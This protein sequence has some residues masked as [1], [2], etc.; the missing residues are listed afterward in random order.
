MKRILLMIAV[1]LM[2]ISADAQVQFGVRG[3]LNVSKE[4]DQIITTIVGNGV[5]TEEI[6]FSNDMKWRAGVNVG[7]FVNI[8]ENDKFDLEIGLSYSMQ[9]YDDK[10]IEI[11]GRG[12]KTLDHKVTSHYLTIPIAEK[13][14]PTGKG[15]Y[16]EL[17]PQL[18][19]LLSK[20]A[21]VGGGD[22]YTPFKDDNRTLDFGILGGVGYVFPSGMFLNARY[23]HGLTETCKV[24]SGGKNRNLQLSLGY[25]F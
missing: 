2:A 22:S 12:E 21:T 24:L 19:I 3:G 9:G 18:G 23:I 10:I 15:F 17:G 16:M 20:K 13:F 4:S 8:P 14:Y 25:L 7:G 1:I 5:A 6:N 11:D